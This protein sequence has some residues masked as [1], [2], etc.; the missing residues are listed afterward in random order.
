MEKI[1]KK[2]ELIKPDG[3]KE[4]V[5]EEMVEI[6]NENGEKE[7]VFKG[8]LEKQQKAENLF[9]SKLKSIGINSIE[10]Y[11]EI[12]YPKEFSLKVRH[13]KA[14]ST[15]LEPIQEYEKSE[16]FKAIEKLEKEINL[17][18]LNN[19]RQVRAAGDGYHSCNNMSSIISTTYGDVLYPA[20]RCV[21]YEGGDRV[22]ILKSNGTF[23]EDYIPQSS[24]RLIHL[25]D[26][27][28]GHFDFCLKI[29]GSYVEI[30]DL[31]DARLGWIDDKDCVKPNHIKVFAGFKAGISNPSLAQIAGYWLDFQGVGSYT[32]TFYPYHGFVRT[33]IR[34]A[35]NSQIYC[36]Y[37]SK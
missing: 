12:R 35:T 4:I 10:E 2:V 19:L 20:E 36:M 29:R 14:R 33:N 26:L 21:W 23:G 15:E 30:S 17:E 3:S 22:L 5:T 32:G 8:L 18:T 6:V 9:L 31:N 28:L 11:N 24:S 34:S 16:K 7:L 25:D 13:S 27:V 37:G 1:L